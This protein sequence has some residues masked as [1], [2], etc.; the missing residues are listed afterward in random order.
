MSAST[1]RPTPQRPTSPRPSRRRA[2]RTRGWR[3]TPSGSP[4]PGGIFASG[5]LPEGH[6]LLAETQDAVAAAGAPRPSALGAPY[7]TDL[8][9]YAVAGIPTLQYGPGDIRYAHAHDEHVAIKELE[10]AARAYALLAIRR[11]GIA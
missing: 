8:R 4:G 3:S 10:Q 1:S 2:P 11:C 9:L 5:R 7:G 6:Q